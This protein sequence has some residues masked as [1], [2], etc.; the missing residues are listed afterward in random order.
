MELNWGEIGLK[1]LCVVAFVFL[2]ALLLSRN[3]P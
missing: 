2:L 3:R 1:L